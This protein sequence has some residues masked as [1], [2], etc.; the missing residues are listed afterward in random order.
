MGK[1]KF[2]LYAIIAYVAYELYGVVQFCKP[3]FIGK[4]HPSAVGP[5]FKPTDELK[6]EL[7]LFPAKNKK[8]RHL[9]TSFVTYPTWS[10]E[11]ADHRTVENFTIPWKDKNQTVVAEVVAFANGKEFNRK[12]M[13]LS[14]YLVAMNE[15]D[16]KRDLLD[17]PSGA[18]QRERISKFGPPKPRSSIPSVIEVGFVLEENHLDS[19]DLQQRGFAEFL[20]KKHFEM[21]LYL[22]TFVIPRDEYLPC[23]QEFP[24]ELRFRVIGFGFWMAQKLLSDSFAQAEATMGMNSYDIDSFKA[25]MSGSSPWKLIIVYAVALLHLVFET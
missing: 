25:L 3:P 14:R 17:D 16:G 2:L 6:F 19:G 12:K 10:S 5:Q 20:Q 8:N 4:D 11:F 24:F 1:S 13:T 21:P 9:I 15:R 22:N 18:K 7:Y 23:D